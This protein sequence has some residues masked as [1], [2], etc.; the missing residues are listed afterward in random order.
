MEI[1][2]D[3]VAMDIL[4]I[5][6]RF[7]VSVAIVIIFSMVAARFLGYLDN[8]AEA[9]ESR[10]KSWDGIRKEDNQQW[11]QLLT[12]QTMA[13]QAMGLTQSEFYKMVKD[14]R[15]T[16]VAYQNTTSTALAELLVAIK[17]VRGLPDSLK[18]VQADLSAQLTKTQNA[19]I[20]AESR[21]HLENTKH[22]ANTNNAILE[23]QKGILRIE[24]ALAQLPVAMQT[25]MLPMVTMLE[26]VL[27]TAQTTQNKID[28]LPLVNSHVEKDLLEVIPTPSTESN[29]A[30]IDEAVA[31]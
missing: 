12:G 26:Q 24:K 3:V 17:D 20:E 21:H 2:M 9:D 23:V 6:E 11:A 13:I 8:R 1:S 4:T 5:P 31:E 30:K 29:G 10:Q 27:V 28:D 22:S 16:M 7:G 14:D 15:V 18:K 19:F 25:T